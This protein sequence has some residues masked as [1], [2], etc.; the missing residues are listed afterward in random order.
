MLIYIFIFYDAPYFTWCITLPVD[1]TTRH[2]FHQFEK[3]S[4]EK[5]VPDSKNR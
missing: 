3:F 2:W 5:R 4:H 1:I